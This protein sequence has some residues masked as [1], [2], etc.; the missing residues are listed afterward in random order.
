MIRLVCHLLFNVRFQYFFS[1]WCYDEL[2]EEK[3]PTKTGRKKNNDVNFA[4]LE[5]PGVLS[6]FLSSS[7]FSSPVIRSFIVL[8]FFFITIPISFTISYCEL[9]S[10]TFSYISNVSYSLTQT[11]YSKWTSIFCLVFFLVFIQLLIQY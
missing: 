2:E 6:C 5:P 7:S 11:R 9:K 10:T 3:K 1:Y 8:F 4:S